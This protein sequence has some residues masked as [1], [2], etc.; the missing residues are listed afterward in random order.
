M[1]TPDSI[2]SGVP[3]NAE[4]A[5]SESCNDLNL[6]DLSMLA[7]V[8]SLVSQPLRPLWFRVWVSGGKGF[9]KSTIYIYIYICHQKTSY[10]TTVYII[11]IYH[12]THTFVYHKLYHKK[13]PHVYHITCPINCPCDNVRRPIARKLRCKPEQL[14]EAFDRANPE[15]VIAA[16]RSA[17]LGMVWCNFLPPNF[18]ELLRCMNNVR[19]NVAPDIGIIWN[20]WMI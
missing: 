3:R 15:M 6:R 14:D 1:S 18:L 12:T 20:Y 9:N 7:Y 19:Q 2:L 8:P 16:R 5:C 10:Y 4:G 17:F 13:A 11:L